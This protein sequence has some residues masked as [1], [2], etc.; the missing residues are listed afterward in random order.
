M[1]IQGKKRPDD[2]LER[3]LEDVM[4]AGVGGL[5]LD[6][7]YATKAGRPLEFVFGPTAGQ[8]TEIAEGI[9]QG[10]LVGTAVKATPVVRQVGQAIESRNREAGKKKF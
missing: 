5:W 4:Y 9:S 1:L 6:I 7:Y 8:A 2:V 3:M 10:D